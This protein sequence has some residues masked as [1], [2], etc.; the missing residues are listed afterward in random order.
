M[1]RRYSD[2]EVAWIRENYPKG[3]VAETHRAFCDRFREV[4]LSAYITKARK[5]GVRRS[6][7]IKWTDEMNAYFKEIVPGHEEHEIREL[8][9]ERFGFELT[10]GQIGNRKT[11]LGVKS[12]THGGRFEVGRAGGFN[13]DEHR[14]RFLEA[15]KA[16]RFKKGNMPTNGRDKPVGYERVTKDGYVEVKV[17]ERP[18]KPFR[19][20]NFRAKSHIEWER[21]HGKPVP[22]GCIVVFANRDKLDFSE[23]NLVLVTRAQ[24]ARI[25]KRGIGYSDRETLDANIA[26]SDLDAAISS[27]VMSPRPCKRC[28]AEFKPRFMRQRTCD[29]CLGR[30]SE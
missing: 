6:A 24:W 4:G 29:A 8:F 27:V 15:G 22:D 7:S 18:S 5:I 21:I 19:N 12:G 2:E 28:G 16:T 3:N 9:A 11:F 23:D 26:L 1:G 13:S 20:D 10:E 14:R 17:A 25:T 30:G